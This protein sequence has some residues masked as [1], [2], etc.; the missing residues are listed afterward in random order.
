MNRN[1]RR[2]YRR[3]EQRCKGR[4]AR[5][6]VERE[7]EFYEG[8]AR[9]ELERQQYLERKSNEHFEYD[10]QSTQLEGPSYEIGG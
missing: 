4:I 10:L 7:V 6:R 3:S 2:N 1:L 8:E 9:E 5:L